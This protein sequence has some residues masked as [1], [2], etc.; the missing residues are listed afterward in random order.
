M[1][2]TMSVVALLFTQQPVTKTIPDAPACRTCRIEVVK[3]GSVVSGERD[4][5]LNDGAV[6]ARGSRGQYFAR[7][8]DKR[9]IAYD[10]AGRYQ[11]TFGTIGA[12]PGEMGSFNYL[13][14]GR[15]DSVW[16]WH[17][18]R[19]FSVFSPRGELVRA[20][21]Y[22]GSVGGVLPSGS[23]VVISNLAASIVKLLRPDGTL[24]HQFTVD[25]PATGV[26]C[27]ECRRHSI[28]VARSGDA[29]WVTRENQYRLEK[30]SLD[31]KLQ[32]VVIRQAPWFPP[33]TRDGANSRAVS[34]GEV[35]PRGQ[36]PPLPPPI[37]PAIIS[38]MEPTTNWIREDA[39][40]L[41]WVGVFRRRNA[42]GPLTPTVEVI[43][44]VRGELLA[45]TELPPYFHSISD[46][47][48]STQKQSSAGYFSFDIWQLV[49][50]RTSS[51]LR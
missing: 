49:L 16:A 47:Y 46:G 32:L 38:A 50:K 6:L 9:I 35:V 2:L 17:G 29:V 18:N 45:S 1:I 43:D 28:S 39:N 15:G 24:D 14:V 12:G 11:R 31:G 19:T 8:T 41:I 26:R 7:S 25:A 22:S 44:P 4:P 5:D 51:S 23:I 27:N 36:V 3:V 48:W 30:W 20:G 33:R 10:S 37:D 40:G 21:T 13:T 34:F 42:V